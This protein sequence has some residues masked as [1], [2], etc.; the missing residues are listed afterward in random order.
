MLLLDGII[1]SEEKS[2]QVEKGQAMRNPLH[3]LVEFGQKN[4]IKKEILANKYA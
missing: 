4:Q 2:T 1:S 3:N